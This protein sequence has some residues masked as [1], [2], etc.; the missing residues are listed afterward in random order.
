VPKIGS[1][2][3]V[4]PYMGFMTQGSEVIELKDESRAGDTLSSSF[5]K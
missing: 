2:S 1:A 5:I 3:E 4:K